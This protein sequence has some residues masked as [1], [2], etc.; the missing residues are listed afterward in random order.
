[1]Y[2]LYYRSECKISLSCKYRTV[3]PSFGKAIG[4]VVAGRGWFWPGGLEYFMQQLLA[5]DLEAG[6]QSFLTVI[7]G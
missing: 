7:C 6:R 2:V 3:Q 5:C 4:A 1:M